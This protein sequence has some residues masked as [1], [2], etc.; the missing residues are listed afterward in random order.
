MREHARVCWVEHEEPWVLEHEII[1][2]VRLPLNLDQNRE[3][4][5]HVRL[6]EVRAAAKAR[7][8]GLPVWAPGDA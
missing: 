4:P 3:R 8:R 5:F 7:A 2:A 6:T 1:C